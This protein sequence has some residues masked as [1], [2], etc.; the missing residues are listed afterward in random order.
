MVL[1][2]CL[3]AASDP[4]PIPPPPLAPG[5]KEAAEL[6]AV[7]NELKKLQGSIDTRDI[8]RGLLDDKNRNDSERIKRSPR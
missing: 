3:P 1:L 7:A 5:Q 2:L 8:Q 6:E 4:P